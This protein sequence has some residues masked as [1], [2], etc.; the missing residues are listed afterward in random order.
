MFHLILSLF[1]LLV[2]N[3]FANSAEI[4]KGQSSIVCESNQLF[5]VAIEKLNTKLHSEIIES[6]EVT[7][8]I[9]IKAPFHA[10][11]MVYLQEGRER[12]VCVTVTKD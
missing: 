9:V 1:I 8:N 3:S 4:V 2:T 7:S 6:R 10:S 5:S 12:T 11:S